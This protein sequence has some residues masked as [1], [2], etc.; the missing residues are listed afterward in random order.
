MKKL[1]LI[2][3]GVFFLSTSVSAQEYKL[4]MFKHLF[5]CIIIDN[6]ANN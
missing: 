1:L 2:V 4:N 5:F 3:F 6:F